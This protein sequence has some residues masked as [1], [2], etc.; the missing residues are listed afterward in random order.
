MAKKILGL[1]KTATK[2][3]RRINKG[4]TKLVDK[5]MTRTER[6]AVKTEKK[7]VGANKKK[8]ARITK[9]AIN[10][11]NRIVK[12]GEKKYD[13]KVKRANKIIITGK[14]GAGRAIKKAAATGKKIAAKGK[15]IANSKVGK[16]AVGA[17]KVAKALK[18]GK[19]SSAVKTV[20]STVKAVKG[21]PKRKRKSKK[22]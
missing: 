21:M 18:G 5:V 14:T 1:S 12:R 22:A 10:K 7:L 4:K 13:R 19:I 2:R 9:R 20:A 3:V 6:N 11:K 15:K 8:S 16:I 17:F